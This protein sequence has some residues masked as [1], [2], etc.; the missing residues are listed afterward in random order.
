MWIGTAFWANGLFR[1]QMICSRLVLKPAT[2]DL[3]ATPQAFMVAR[4][5]SKISISLVTCLTSTPCFDAVCDSIRRCKATLMMVVFLIDNQSFQQD[6]GRLNY[7]L[8]KC[9]SYDVQYSYRPLT[10]SQSVWC[11]KI[12]TGLY[13]SC[14]CPS[15]SKSDK[16]AA[17]NKSTQKTPDKLPTNWFDR[18]LYL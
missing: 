11:V 8:F 6:C 1:D 10:T 7:C 5:A 14:F 18:I 12:Y 9:S 4:E 3:Y 2:T 13:D 16:F 15:T 17:E